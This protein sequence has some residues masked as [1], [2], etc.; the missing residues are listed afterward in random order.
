MDLARS[1]CMISPFTRRVLSFAGLSLLLANFAI[2]QTPDA[3]APAPAA[4]AG[5]KG[6][7]PSYTYWATVVRVIDGDTVL[8]NVD[9]GFDT[10][11]HNRSI[12]LTG[13]TAPSTQGTDKAEGFKWKTR[14]QELLPV[15]SE[16]VIQ[17]SKDKSTGQV[18]YLGVFWLDGVNVNEALLNPKQH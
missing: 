10:W 12:D 7:E 11:S 3:P 16:V 4:K 15:G 1:F 13:I 6:P 8:L 18:R 5:S 17:S 2:G 9:L 14:L